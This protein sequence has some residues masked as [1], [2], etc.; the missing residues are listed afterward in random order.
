MD[1]IEVLAFYLREQGHDV[2]AFPKGD[3]PHCWVVC[4]FPE[5]DYHY[6]MYVPYKQEKFIISEREEA[7]SIHS[8]TC[9]SDINS[10]INL[11]KNFLAYEVRKNNRSGYGYC[12]EWD[13]DLIWSKS[14][15]ENKEDIYAT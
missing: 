15:F 8:P 14:Q 10:S 7:F 13:W 2:D 11:I 12:Y 3:T 5:S 4:T 1:A 6:Q 9:F